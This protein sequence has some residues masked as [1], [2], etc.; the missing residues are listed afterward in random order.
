[1]HVL[2]FSTNLSETEGCSE[3]L[4]QMCKGFRGKYPLLLQILMKI[5]FFDRFSKNIQIS[6]LTK[7]LSSGSRDVPC[8]RPDG[9][10]DR[11]T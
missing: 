6:K 3:V 8:G 4:L 10:R 9:R 2:V 1:M 11:Q 7:K 5:E